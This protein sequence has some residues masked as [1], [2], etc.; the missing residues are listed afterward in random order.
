MQHWNIYHKWN[1][2]LFRECYKAYKEGRATSNP[3]E[4]WYEEEIKFFDLWVIP[5]ARKLQDCGVFGVSSFEYLDYALK[6]R[7]E[8][9]ER[10]VEVVEEMME[11]VK[12]KEAEI[13][14]IDDDNC[15]LFE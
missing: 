15:A 5:L 6:N 14:D 11:S 3:C 12:A 2:R 9:E 1:E 7:E 13:A 8:W 10:G 4:Y